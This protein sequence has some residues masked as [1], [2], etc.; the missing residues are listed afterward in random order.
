[1]AKRLFVSH[2]VPLL[3]LFSLL[4][5]GCGCK[6]EWNAANCTTPKTCTVCETTDGGV[7]GHNYVNGN[8]NSCGGSDPNYIYDPTVWIPTN[9]G[10]RYHSKSSCSNMIDPMQVTKSNAEAQGFTPCGRCY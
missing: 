5:T 10:E 3:V 7:L 2:A 4:L 9:G 8:C 1:M 6:H